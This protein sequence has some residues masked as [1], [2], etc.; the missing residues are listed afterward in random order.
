[1]LLVSAAV[2]A[3]AARGAEQAA[4]PEQI[5]GDEAQQSAWVQALRLAQTGSFDQAARQVDGILAGGVASDRVERVDK[6]LHAIAD[7]QAK[8]Q[9]QAEQDYRT[10]VEWVRQDIEGH[11]KDHRRGWWR[12]AVLDCARAYNSAADRDAVLKEPWFMEVAADAAKAAEQYEEANKWLEAARIYGPLSDMMRLNKDYRRALE[13][14]QAHLRIEMLY[15]A[16]SDWEATVKNIFPS[17]A[18][19]ALRKIEEN[20]LTEPSFR[21]AAVAGLEQMLRLVR[22]E[23]VQKVFPA[24]ADKDKTEEFCDRIEVRLQQVKRGGSMDAEGLTDLFER[25]LAI[26]KELDLLPQTV[27]IHEFVHGALQP[28][29]PFS[30]MLWPSDILEFNKHTQGKFCGVGIQIR[31]QNNEPILVVSPLDDTTP[32]YKKGIQPGDLITEIEGKSTEKININ[33]A[34]RQITGPPGTSVTVTIKRPGVDQPFQVKLERQEITILTIKGYDRKENGQWDYL[35][36]PEQKIGYVRMTNFTEGTIDELQQT[37]KTLCQ[38]QG[39]RGLIFDLRGNPGGPLKAAVDVSDLFLAGNQKIVSTKDR[40]GQEWSKSSTDQEKF[41][42]FPMIIL[43]DDSTAS[44]SE[45]VS[46]ALQVH[47][48]ARILGERTF[49]KGSVQQVLPL[50][51]S[52]MAYL[53]LTTAHYSLPNGRCL[54]R[55]EDST[56]WGVDPDIQVR[57][58]PKEFVRTN[59]LRLKKD[60]LKG[61]DQTKLTEDELDAVTHYRGK[62]SSEDEEAEDEAKKEATTKPADSDPD[63]VDE[64]KLT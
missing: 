61:K 30:D 59:E 5:I 34:V 16:D 23:K 64:S 18:T 29:D 27:V 63:D 48:R 44:A 11:K 41:G 62:K 40:Q 52:N 42:D 15:S 1:M 3:P 47:R 55:E 28:L 8:R 49:G 22:T 9:D 50:N 32:A 17:M 60:I 2:L 38:E 53:K 35:I 26:N 4:R 36:D 14:C 19:D 20:Y 25:V 54:H 45:I 46:G 51:K 24:L 37:L 12:L 57:L 6:W 56:T 13:R 33:E 39:M 58:V 7:L 43:V 10:Y 31:K 21:E